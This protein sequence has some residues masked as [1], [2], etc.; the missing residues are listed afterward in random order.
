MDAARMLGQ[1]RER[2]PLVVHVTNIV[3][4]NQCA[5]IC[6]CTGG[7]P[8]MSMSPSDAAE[9]ARGADA[10]VVNIGTLDS[11]HVGDALLAAAN[12]AAD[13]GKPLL[14]DPVGAGAT[15]LRTAVAKKI[16][17]ECIPRSPSTCVVKGNA[18][19]IGYLSGLGGE[20]RGVD[21]SGTSDQRRSA[22][23]LASELGCVVASTGP[24][25]V[26][27][28]GASTSVLE[29]GTPMLGL[30]TG[31]GCM[32]SSVIGC[33]IGACAVSVDSVS[34]GINTFNIAAEKAAAKA[35]E[36]AE[37]TA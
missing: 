29:R 20:V 17:S 34:A 22:E 16:M 27:S 28:D 7:S 3:T 2:R 5:N 14:I 10:V 19:E 26:V 8:C 4:A 12:A 23:A 6:I 9:L 31:T 11:G 35:T 37:G 18:G 25:D 32:V 15:T 24:T 13:A 30:V 33:F 36:A 1:V 21:S